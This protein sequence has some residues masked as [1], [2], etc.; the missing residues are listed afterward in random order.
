MLT[1]TTVFAQRHGN[2]NSSFQNQTGVCLNNISGLTEKQQEQIKKIQNEHQDEMD[3]LREKRRSTSNAIEKSE[4]RTDMLKKA[5]AHRNLVKK[6]LTA[7]QQKQYDQLHAFGDSDRNQQVA[8]GCGARN[9][10]GRGHGNRDIS[11]GKNGNGTCLN[12]N[13]CGRGGNFSRGNDRGNGNGRY[14]AND[15]E[16]NF[17]GRNTID[18]R[19]R[20]NKQD[21][22]VNRN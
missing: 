15:C 9:F 13:F 1:T 11:R 3:K 8:S 4:T 18:G 20:F 21:S 6:V 2:G 5:E 14:A 12:T 16:T 19:G 17:R 22:S 10:K 7:E